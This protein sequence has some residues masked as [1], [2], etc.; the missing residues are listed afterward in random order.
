MHTIQI[1]NNTYSLPDNWDELTPDQLLYLVKLTTSNIPVEEVKVYMMLYCLKA[2]I[3]RHN[4]RFHE[5]SPIKIGKT[6]YLLHPE[7]ISALADQLSFLLLLNH[8]QSNPDRKLYQINPLLTVN[9]YPSIRCRLH[10]F[11]GPDDNMWD[12]TFEQFMYMQAY[13]DAMQSDATKIDYL[14]ACLWHFGKYF[15]INHIEKDA[16]TLKHLPEDKKMIMYWFILG[17][18]SYMASFFPRIFSGDGKTNNNGRIF[19]AQLRLLDSLAQSDMTK[20]PE[21]RKGLLLDAFYSMDESIR[22]K[23]ETEE[24]LNNNS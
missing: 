22:R 20:K 10:K 4:K 9:P 13:L 2:H 16:S 21:I 8:D 24:R 15:D 12:I 23:E 3:C 14:L 17:S 7:E 18:L 1:N 19:D 5:Y 11:T 6:S